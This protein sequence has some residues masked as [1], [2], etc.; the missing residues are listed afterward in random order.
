MKCIQNDIK[1][2]KDGTTLPT[3]ERADELNQQQQQRSTAR[4]RQHAS[5]NKHNHLLSI[6]V[7]EI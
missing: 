3:I 1:H 2:N 7:W 5:G 4:A 6:H